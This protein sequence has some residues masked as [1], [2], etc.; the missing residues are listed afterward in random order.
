MAAP[1]PNDDENVGEP[2]R[3]D[4]A[5]GGTGGGGGEAEILAGWY[6]MAGVGIEFVVAIALCAGVG[7]AI[8]RWRGSSPWG[9]LIG[10]ALGFA[11]GLRSLIR[12]AKRSFK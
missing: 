11:V 4:T 3:T 6:R 2:K 9:V 10:L 8:D 12:V 7:Y 5:S 1:T